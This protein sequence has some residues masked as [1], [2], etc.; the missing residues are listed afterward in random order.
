MT[1]RALKTS[2]PAF[3]LTKKREIEMSETIFGIHSVDTQ[4]KTPFGHLETLPFSPLAPVAPTLPRIPIAP[5]SPN[6]EQ[7]D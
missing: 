2:F 6:H 5:V 7:I 4:P 1:F 3:T